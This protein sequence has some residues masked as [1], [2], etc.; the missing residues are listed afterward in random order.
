MAPGAGEAGTA[1]RKTQM[2]NSPMWAMRAHT[3]HVRR[4]ALDMGGLLRF[5]LGGVLGAVLGF[6]LSRSRSGTAARRPAYLPETRLVPQSTV[7]VS[8]VPVPVAFEPARHPCPARRPSPAHPQTISRS[9]TGRPSA[10][11][12]LAGEEPDEESV[13][14]FEWDAEEASVPEARLGG[15]RARGNARGNAGE[16]LPWPWNWSRQLRRISV[17][18]RPPPP[19]YRSPLRRWERVR[20]GP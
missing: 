20:V 10:G 16:T 19:R 17:R 15:R 13:S 7:V 3:S 5:L 1:G 11:W 9:L 4:R 6:F 18:H 8:A 2:S 14:A 12:P